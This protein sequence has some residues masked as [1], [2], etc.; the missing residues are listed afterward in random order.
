M[1]CAHKVSLLTDIFMEQFKIIGYSRSPTIRIERRKYWK[2]R[3]TSIYKRIIIVDK[4]VTLS[5]NRLV[6]TNRYHVTD[7]LRCLSR[8][9]KKLLYLWLSSASGTIEQNLKRYIRH[10]TH[11][12]CRAAFTFDLSRHPVWLFSQVF[13]YENGIKSTKW[14]I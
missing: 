7:S 4:Q 11:H 9:M 13:G 12:K 6:M 2:I 1:C 14:Q 3:G 8:F 10:R 5:A